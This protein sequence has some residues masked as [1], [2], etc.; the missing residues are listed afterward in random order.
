MKQRILTLVMACA[1]VF[2]LLAGCGEEEKGSVYWLNFKPEA[3]QA[4]QQIAKTYREQ[5]GVE[6]RIVTAASGQYESTLTA[7]MDKSRITYF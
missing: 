1:L 7:E 2:G 5:T 4:L 6:V 3:D